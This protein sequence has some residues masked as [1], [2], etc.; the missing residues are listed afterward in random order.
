MLGRI[1]LATALL[2]FAAMLLL[3]VA[4][5]IGRNL[6]HAALPGGDVMLRH[7][8]LWVALP[9]AALA[10]SAN[11]HLHLDPANLAARP[12]WQRLTAIPFHLASAFV[13]VLLA[14]AAWRYWQDE[15]Q[16]Q[17]AEAG[18]LVWLGLILPAAFALLA[19]HFLLRAALALPSK[20]P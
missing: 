16:Y 14:A 5:I 15:M 17:A 1:E 12:T 7:L 6:F 20:T 11:R 19:V 2:A 10:V 3:S 13:C 9:G 4:E 18:W 8:V